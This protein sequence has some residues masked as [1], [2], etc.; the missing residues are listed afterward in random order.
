MGSSVST[1]PDIDAV[2]NLPFALRFLSEQ[3]KISADHAELREV[4]AVALSQ[5]WGDY[6]CGHISKQ[7]AEWINKSEAYQAASYVD[8]NWSYAGE[9]WG[10]D[11]GL[12]CSPA[13]I[14]RRAGRSGLVNLNETVIIAMGSM[15]KMEVAV[16]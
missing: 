8:A 9:G 13:A 16:Y 11:G 7:T 1:A 12:A 5:L 3:I 14:G 10:K 15:W 4:Y 2:G 6:G